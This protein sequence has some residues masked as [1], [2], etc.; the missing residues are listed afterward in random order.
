MQSSIEKIIEQ[1]CQTLSPSFLNIEN[2]SANHHGPATDSHFKITIVCAAF[3]GK[4]PVPRHQMMYKLLADE[5]AGCVHALALHTFTD[6]EYQGTR[7]DSPNCM[8][9]NI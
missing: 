1:K 5:M 3:E 4:R 8:G 6:S 2:E 9:K 7:P